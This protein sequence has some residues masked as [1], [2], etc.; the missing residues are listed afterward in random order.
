LSG[1]EHESCTGHV[2]LPAVNTFMNKP[3]TNRNCQ[4]QYNSGFTLVELIVYIAIVSVFIS[5][6]IVFTWNAIFTSEKAYIQHEVDHSVR[7]AGERISY[8]IR[9]ATGITSITPNS[10][11]LSS[12]DAA[13]NPTVIS[14]SS[15]ALY[16]GFGPTGTCSASSPCMLTPSDIMIN[17]AS[18]ADVSGG[19][20]KA[21][22]FQFD[23]LKLGSRPEF[24]Y[25]ASFTTSAQVRR[26]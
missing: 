13:R 23:V 20:Q 26:E 22:R 8:E 17:N 15:G 1:A 4:Y 9:N 5:G 11:T 3:S 25:H 24:S 14:F 19:S 10:I 2:L 21:V 6:A 12:N 7:F 16:L 18:F